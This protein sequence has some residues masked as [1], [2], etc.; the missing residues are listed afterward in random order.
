VIVIN[1]IGTLIGTPLGYVMWAVYSLVNNFAVAIIIFTII[2]KMAMFP[3]TLKQQ[4]NMAVSQL[5]MPKVQEIQTKYKNNRE[6][7]QEE[8]AKLQKQGYNPMGGCGTTLITM[9]LL[10]GIIDVVY[11]PLTNMEHLDWTQKDSPAI[12]VDIARQT[13]Y[14]YAI[15][16]S[17]LDKEI[18]DIYI[19]NGYKSEDLKATEEKPQ[20]IPGENDRIPED[21]IT[22]ISVDQ[23][24]RYGNWTDEQFS[25]LTGSE[26]R[27]S[28]DLKKTLNQAK[29]LMASTQSEL[30]ALK[31]Y[32]QFPES[33]T[34]SDRLTDEAKAK[35]ASLNENMIFLGM[36]F[37][38]T[39]TFGFNA[40]ILIPIFSL[41]FSLAQMLISQKLNEMSNP[42]VAKMGSMKMMIYIMP[43][44]SLFI[45][46]SVP[47]GVG[48]YW[49]VSYLI[50]IGQSLLMFKFWHPSKLREQAKAKLDEKALSVSAT[51]IVK[52]VDEEGN[53]IERAEKVI[54]LS[55]KEQ[56][57]YYRKKLE[58]ARRLDAIKYGDDEVVPLPDPINDDEDE[59]SEPS[60]ENDEE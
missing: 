49:G 21:E 13:Q 51:A 5:F 37:K 59:E 56:K 17:P 1:F 14:T 12:V 15:L 19:D 18:I 2:V 25:V 42:Q 23:R 22:S 50:G 10:F 36:D 4:K 33:F 39:P 24:E 48:F 11:K 16:Q 35:I 43:V 54:N 9:L 26:S 20:I 8:L 7:Q 34:L 29:T 55:A 28:E 31:I 47:A 27:I 30:I 32:D 3:M 44:F 41:L 45:A 58:E 38:Q 52:D 6:K 40:L 60:K 57:E 46:F 53:T